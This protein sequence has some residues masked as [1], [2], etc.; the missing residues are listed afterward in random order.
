MTVDE[1]QFG[2]VFLA[3]VQVRGEAKP[4]SGCAAAQIEIVRKCIYP[5]HI[6]DHAGR[7]KMPPAPIKTN[8]AGEIGHGKSG[9]YSGQLNAIRRASEIRAGAGTLQS[10]GH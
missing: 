10:N 6:A 7:L 3:H 2:Y 8:V 9:P 5:F 4:S 1:R